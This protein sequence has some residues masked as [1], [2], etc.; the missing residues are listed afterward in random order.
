MAVDNS[1]ALQAEEFYA[2]VGSRSERS[3]I[4]RSGVSEFANVVAALGERG[5]TGQ[6]V[7]PM[8][9]V[10]DRRLW[11]R[12][13]APAAAVDALSPSDAAVYLSQQALAAE[14]PEEGETKRAVPAPS[15]NH[16]SVVLW[17]SVGAERVLLGADLEETPQADTGW[18]AILDDADLHGDPA[19]VFKVPHHGSKTAEQPRIW[20]EA[21]GPEPLAM[22]TPFERGR[23]K[24]PTDDDRARISGY[25]PNAYLTST[26]PRGR[27]HHAPPVAR[28]LR[29]MGVR[30]VV[31]TPPLGHVRLRKSVGHS[32]WTCETFGA[33]GPI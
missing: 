17:V 10:R 24:L 4:R 26:R 28:T 11:T 5:G 9:A 25:T 15:P 12:G 22:I 13:A 23:V 31:A 19:T 2:L 21:L 33:A 8:P 20:D 1:G 27:R 3:L 14:L 29:E 16:S 6:P 32:D 7:A 18:T 30:P